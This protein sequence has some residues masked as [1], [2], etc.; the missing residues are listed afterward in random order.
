MKIPTAEELRPI[1]RRYGLR[2]IVLF[3]SQTTGQLHPESDVDVAVWTEK[4]LTLTRRLNLW[5]KL[6]QAFEADVDLAV[7]NRAEPLLMYQV[8]RAGRVLYAGRKWAWDDFHGYA[9]RSYWDTRKF[10][11]DLKPYIH[12]Q[13]EKWGHA[14]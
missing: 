7:L 4:P 13:I 12:R 11:D 10:R 8:A 6:S 5:L 3:G 9:C 2:L 14:G 1:A